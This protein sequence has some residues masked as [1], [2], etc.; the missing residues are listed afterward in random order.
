MIQTFGSIDIA[1]L[2]GAVIMGLGH[3][4]SGLNGNN[5]TLWLI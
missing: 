4:Y 3:H 1:T 5:D 2:T